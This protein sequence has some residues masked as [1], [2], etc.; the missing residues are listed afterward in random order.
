MYTLFA[1][2]VMN[3]ESVTNMNFRKIIFKSIRYTGVPFLI[4]EIV[5]RKKVTIVLFHDIDPIKSDIHFRALNE[6]YT[7][8]SLKRYLDSFEDGT[9]EQL[10][11]KSLIITVDDGNKNNYF[12]KPLL[13][14][15]DIPVTIFLCAGIVGTN[16]HFWFS[17]GL[18]TDTI[19]KLKH[20]SNEQR[21]NHLK[22]FGY[23]DQKEFD[24]RQALSKSEIEDLSKSVDFQSHTLFHPILPKCTDEEAYK[25]IALSRKTLKEQYNFETDVLSYPNGDYGEREILFAKKAG[26]RYGITLDAGYNDSKTD[27]FRLKRFSI[28]DDSDI[29]E[30]LV[31]ASGLWWYLR[32]WQRSLKQR[33]KQI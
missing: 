24:D 30:L 19:E 12:L 11:P 1:E 26:Y 20:L 6:K 18:K 17:H 10:P 27:P 22:K 2:R 5:Q 4:R 7:I 29:D 32:R 9:F 3:Y 28:R 31:K 13:K 33:I 15:Y 16:R 8:I 25:E 21:L 14:K 23:T